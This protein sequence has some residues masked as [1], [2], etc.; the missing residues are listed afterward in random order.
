MLPDRS[1]LQGGLIVSVQAPEGSPM[2]Q[3]EVIAA[4]AEAS[5]NNGAV[6]VRL[7]SPEHI[8]AVRRRCPEALI[9][10]LWKRTYPD[11]PVYITPGWQEIQAVWAAGADVI[12]LDATERLRPDGAVLAELVQRARGDLGAVLMADVDS[13]A[14]GVQAAALGCQ[15]V[16]TTLYGYTEA[17]AALRPPAWDLLPELRR[18]L[19][20]DVLL[21]CE[22]GIASAEQAVQARSLGADAVVV[23]TAI[24]G[25]DLQVAAYQRA[26]EAF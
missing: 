9:V 12:A 19:P 8:G 7:E 15:W 10:G 13:L 6:G 16:G 4:M 17:T 5:L 23:G 11:S 24:T 1:Q 14:N 22:G 26:L 18:E 3:N 2:R 25:V 21:I 20:A